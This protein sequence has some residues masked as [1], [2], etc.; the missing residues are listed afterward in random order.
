VQPTHPQTVAM[1]EDIRVKKAQRPDTTLRD[2]LK[3]VTID[4]RVQDA[5][6]G[7]TLDGFRAKV[8]AATQK[9]F[10]PNFII[11]P[12]ANPVGTMSL[13]FRQMPADQALLYIAEVAGVSLV[14]DKHAI[15]VVPSR[16]APV[17][18]AE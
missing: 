17:P 15:L 16:G 2:K 1:L 14:F 12:D 13:D 4:L 10:T 11:R 5:T 9:Q 8:A 7:E 3:E 18:A 6:L